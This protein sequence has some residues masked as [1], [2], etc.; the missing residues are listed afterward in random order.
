MAQKAHMT[1][2]VLSSSPSNEKNVMSKHRSKKK[3]K[4]KKKLGK[5]EKKK[6]KKKHRSKLT[7]KNTCHTCEPLGYFFISFFLCG[8]QLWCLNSGP[9]TC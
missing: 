7:M 4:K 9:H 6:I 8:E 2:K 3:K 1:G 5:I